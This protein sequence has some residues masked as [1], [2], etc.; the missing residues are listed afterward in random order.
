MRRELSAGGVV[1]HR[2]RGRLFAAVT[3]PRGRPEGFWA[4]PKGLIDPGETAAVAAVREVREETG[5]EGVV[6]AR[7]ADSRYV[8]T[9]DGERVFKIVTFFLLRAR[10]GRIGELPPGMDAEVA[11]VRWVPLDDL[12]ALLAHRGEREVAE[13]ALAAARD[14]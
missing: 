7:L 13:K 9:W 5:L 6:V 3:R 12:P 14:L 8:Y 1:V 11:D 10:G 2:L 4:L